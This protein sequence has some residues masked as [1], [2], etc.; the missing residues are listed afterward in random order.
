MQITTEMLK[1][2][3]QIELKMLE[4]FLQ[5]C[6]KENLRYYLLGGT[7]LG[8]VR[9]KGFIPWD[10]DIDIGMPRADYEKFLASAGKYLP[11]YYFLQTLHTEPDFPFS[12][13]KM[14]DN[15][16]VYQE[17][18]LAKLN[19]HHGV[20]IDIFPLDLYPKNDFWVDIYHRFLQK[21]VSCRFIEKNSL[22]TKFFKLLS[23]FVCPSWKEAVKRRD[24]LMRT[25]ASQSPLTA[26]WCGA[27][28]K[29]EIM[30]TQWYGEGSNLV[31][32]NL[33]VKGPK[34]YDKW[35]TQ[36]YGNYMQL[37][38]IEKRVVRHNPSEI[39]L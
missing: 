1:Q 30:P 21:R 38:P 16:T 2:L 15:R 29:K 8:A 25:A 7:L 39:K 24:R 9:H 14:R 35:L 33:Q 19:I 37:P 4:V 5:I 28:G 26:N 13:A 20:W 31:F 12:F 32:E 23:Y 17:E 11:S 18:A 22:K 10:D 3:Q 34:E 27:W 6:E 36:I